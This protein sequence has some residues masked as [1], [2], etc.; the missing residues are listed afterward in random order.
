MKTSL[1][2]AALL[3][4]YVNAAFPQGS[5]T[6]PGAPAPTMKTLDQV[7]PRT[8]IPGGTA[9]YTISNEG[10]YYLGGNLTISSGNAITV[11][12]NNVTIDLQGFELIGTGGSAGVL[13]NPG[14]SNVTVRN[15]TIRN[16][17]SRAI[18]G[19]GNPNMRV[20]KVR[21]LNNANY[22]IFVDVNGAV[23][24]CLAQS[25]AGPGI[26][27]ADNCVI[28]NCQSI[29]NTGANS[30]GISVG[31]AAQISGCVVRNNAGSGIVTGTG[32]TLTDCVASNNTSSGIN[33]G[34][35]CTILNSTANENGINGSTTAG[36][37]G[38]NAASRCSIS[39]CSGNN[40]TGSGL[41]VSLAGTTGATVHNSIFSSNT[42]DGIQVPTGS[43]VTAC[44][45]AFNGGNGIFIFG[46]S[47]TVANCTATDNTINGIRVQGGSSTVIGNNCNSNGFGAGSGAGIFSAGSDRIE[48]NTV[49]S[50]DRGIQVIG[51]HSL[52]LRNSASGNTD[53]GPAP[54]PNYVIAA[55]NSFGPIVNVSAVGDISGTANA[56]HPWAN[57]SH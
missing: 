51:T 40:N 20:E 55:S 15:G 22:G 33:V 3:F 39:N 48:G 56:N 25:N 14:I 54:A 17:T 35:R 28:H 11:A 52:I 24:D 5:L 46:G 13:I 7:Q 37:H 8:L 34:E 29:G 19:Q 42:L 45:A 43:T 44:S 41:F 18:D 50:N 30:H 32:C 53:P 12:A 1:V 21:A 31:I 9:V 57:F 36:S 2:T 49:Q 6:P 38:I 27:G 26:A 16:F 4:L 47:S 10:S 23:I